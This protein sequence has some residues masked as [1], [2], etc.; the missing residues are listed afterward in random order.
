M[1]TFVFVEFCEDYAVSIADFPPAGVDHYC[2]EE[3]ELI[4]V[5]EDDSHDGVHAE[6]LQFIAFNPS[7]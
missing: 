1:P 2:G 5:S 3:R 7:E 4:D 6:H